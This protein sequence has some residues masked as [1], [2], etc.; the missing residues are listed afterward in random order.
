[1]PTLEMIPSM[2]QTPKA[3]VNPVCTVAGGAIIG[4]T[5]GGGY[6]LL[7]APHPSLGGFLANTAEG[8]VIGG[9]A[10]SGAGLGVLFGVGA[11]SHATAQF[12]TAASDSQTT[13]RKYF[14]WITG[15]K[16][17]PTGSL[18]KAP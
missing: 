6:Y 7:T 5:V 16:V 15:T 14:Y 4:G 10:G 3:F 8:A 11:A 12:V 1:M 18:E 17:I 13:A 9:T 2:R